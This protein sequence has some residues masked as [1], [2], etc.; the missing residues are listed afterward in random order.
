MFDINFN[1]RKQV[2]ILEQSMES[3][4][5][6]LKKEYNNALESHQLKLKQIETA[7]QE[8]IAMYKQKI[9]DMIDSQKAE[10]QLTKDNYMRIVEEIK[11]QYTLM[12]NN[13]KQQKQLEEHLVSNSSEYMQKLD[14][15]LH[16][17]SVAGKTLI[18]VEEKVAEQQNSFAVSKQENLKAK[19]NEIECNKIAQTIHK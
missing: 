2:S 13:L 11:E 18:Q 19:E 12:V 3:M 8:E 15:S 7:H 14:N 6:Y 16:L 1:F 4:E 10:L 17:L 9:S 5:N